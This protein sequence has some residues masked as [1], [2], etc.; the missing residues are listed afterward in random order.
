[1][2]HA[3]ASR[4]KRRR[5]ASCRCS[6]TTPVCRASSSETIHAWRAPGGFTSWQRE[7]KLAFWSIVATLLVGAVTGV[8]VPIALSGGGRSSAKVVTNNGQVN[9]GGVVNNYYGSASA[10]KACPKDT[11]TGA[12]TGRSDHVVDADL[13]VRTTERGQC[14]VRAITP[15]DSPTLVEYEVEYRNTSSSVQRDVEIRLKLARGITM[16]PHSTYLVNSTTPHGEPITSTD[17]VVTDGILIGSYAPGA[18]AYVVITASTPA[19]VDLRCGSNLLRT[20]VFVQPKGDNFFNNTADAT[21][22]KNDCN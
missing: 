12:P 10:A 22:S 3:V 8:V 1:M 5:S 19:L 16:I 21:I 7:H 4:Q 14:W 2:Q 20:E 6:A 11:A 13:Y 15:R 9:V 18:G 17:A